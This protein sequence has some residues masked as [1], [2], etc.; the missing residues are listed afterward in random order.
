MLVDMIKDYDTEQK[1]FLKE[2]RAKI[3]S[4]LGQNYDAKK[5]FTF[6]SKSGI[7]SVDEKT[8]HIYI[9]T[10]N[11]FSLSQI[12]KFLT[13]GLNQAIEEVYNPQFSLKLVCYAPFQ[14]TK[15]DLLIDLKK[16]LNISDKPEK[17]MKIDHK[18]KKTF[19][20]QFGIM[21]DEKFTF[22]N[23]VAG[24]SSKLAFNAAMQTSEKPGLVYNPLFIYGQVGLGKTHLMQ[25]IGNEIM[26][27]YPDKVVVYLPATKLIDE[28]VDATRKNKMHDLMHRLD[29][30]DVL[31]VDDIQF[32]AEKE[33]TQEVFHNIFNDFQSKKKQIILTS[34]RAPRELTLLEE[35][36]R[37]RFAYGLVCDIKA[38]DYE[39]RVAILQSKLASRGEKIDNESLGLIAKHIKTN[40]RELEGVLNILMTRRALVD[41]ELD[42]DDILDSLSTLGY[43]VKEEDN[44]QPMAVSNRSTG[45]YG[46]IVEKT[47]NYYNISVNDVR[48]DSRKKEI[49]QARQMLMFIAKKY[50]DRTLEKIGDYFGGRNH[51]TVIY[52][53]ENF[54]KLMRHDKQL[55]Q[56]L[57]V[58]VDGL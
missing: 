14:T 43:K 16:V 34:D 38:P 21:F 39:T 4:H 28:I 45:A 30:I 33:K 26:R 24:S 31:M 19:T 41:K 23:F 6:L 18:T 49:S 51:A 44:E 47:A 15:H 40:V 17:E 2:L 56:D 12:K 11:E 20:D 22:D 58:M 27:L 55:E 5:I 52:A 13:K 3:V 50:F 8:Q 7:I 42:R 1:Q 57:M 36:L 32:I 29:N 25:A 35:R 54:E 37:T 9:G 46:K 10:A 53:I 48:G